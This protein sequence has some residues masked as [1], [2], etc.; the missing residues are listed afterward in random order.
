M[1]EREIQIP[2]KRETRD[3]IKKVKGMQTYSQFFESMLE[4]G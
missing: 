4:L 2:V 3:K 1:A